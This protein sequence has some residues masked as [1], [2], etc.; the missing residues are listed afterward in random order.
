VGC[1]TIKSL[2]DRLEKYWRKTADGPRIA[3]ATDR[4]FGYHDPLS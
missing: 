2:N 4:R 3:A 1:T